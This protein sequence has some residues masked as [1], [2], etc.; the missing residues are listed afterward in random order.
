M[1]ARREDLLRFFLMLFI[2]FVSCQ[3]AGNQAHRLIEKQQSHIDDDGNDHRMIGKGL[4]I[5]PF[6]VLDRHD[7]G[8]DQQHEEDQKE[9]DAKK[10]I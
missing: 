7:D 2:Q 4:Q 10:H 1:G 5:Q 8:N 9:K 6:V 3:Q